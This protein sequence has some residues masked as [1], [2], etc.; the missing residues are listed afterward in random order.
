MG[1]K[2]G[3]IDKIDAISHA[4]LSSNAIKQAVKNA[5]SSSK[6]KTVDS[7]GLDSELGL[8]SHS[9]TLSF[10][11]EPETEKSEAEAGIELKPSNSD[12]NIL[13]KN[14]SKPESDSELNKPAAETKSEAG[15]NKE[16]E[17][18]EELKP[19]T[20]LNKAIKAKKAK[21]E[22]KSAMDNKNEAE[23]KAEAAE[24]AEESEETAKKAEAVKESEVIKETE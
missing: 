1:K 23:L 3:D 21:E 4:T 5:F 15:L 16:A 6:L 12:E 2:K 18:K 8:D 17:S 9:K 7:F 20:E 24:K 19:D 22:V 11:A 10:T 14:D 13:N